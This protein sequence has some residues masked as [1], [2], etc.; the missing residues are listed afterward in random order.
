MRKRLITSALALAAGSFF[1]LGSGDYPVAASRRSAGKKSPADLA[2]LAAAEEK[3]A[4]K[5]AKR[6]RDALRCEHGRVA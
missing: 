4:R 3:R 5:D 6:R 2:R 1:G